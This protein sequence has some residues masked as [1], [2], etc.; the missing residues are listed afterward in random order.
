MTVDAIL[1]DI[2]PEM[3]TLPTGTRARWIG[4]ATP[5]VGF[6]SGDMKDMA[7]AYLAA[8][9]YTVSVSTRR[10]IGGQVLSETEGQLSRTFGKVTDGQELA[11][12]GYGQEYLRLAKMLTINPMTRL[13]MR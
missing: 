11:Q 9:M 10:T 2:A 13:W 6:G 8:H 7:I 5:Q 1:I 3:A 4:Y 12:T